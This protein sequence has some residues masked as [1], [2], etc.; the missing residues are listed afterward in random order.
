MHGVDTS[1]ITQEVIV[2]ISYSGDSLYDWGSYYTVN[3]SAVAIQWLTSLVEIRPND[4]QPDHTHIYYDDFCAQ[5][6]KS[7]KY[8]NM[9]YIP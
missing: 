4:G 8:D 5:S 6:H 2:G 7:Y 9:D 1:S 3:F